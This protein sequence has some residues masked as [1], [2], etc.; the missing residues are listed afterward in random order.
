MQLPELGPVYMDSDNF[1]TRPLRPLADRETTALA[2]VKQKAADLQDVILGLPAGRDR[3][4]AITLLE[5][6]VMRAVR[7]VTV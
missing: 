1:R 7:A 4:L 2:L 6:A 5:D 3:S